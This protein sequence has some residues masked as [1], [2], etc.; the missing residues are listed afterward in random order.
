MDIKRYFF[1]KL[2]KFMGLTVFSKLDLKRGG[3]D[4]IILKEKIPQLRKF[5]ELSHKSRQKLKPYYEQYISKVSPEEWAISFELSVFLMVLCDILKPKRILDLGS[6]FSSLVFRLYMSDI[7]PKPIVWSVDTSSKWL[8]ETCRF[9]EFNNLTTENLTTWHNFLKEDVDSFDLI[10][11][12]LGYIPIRMMTLKKVLTLASPKGIIVLDD[13]NRIIYR[14]YVKQ[15]LNKSK[16]DYYS[17]KFFT[18]DDYER[19]SMLVSLR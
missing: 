12:D 16:L 14:A 10:L 19:F 18:R 8:E 17:L 1:L 11:H 15:I 9:L 4:M 5:D 7:S 2:Y 6:G 13:I 3:K